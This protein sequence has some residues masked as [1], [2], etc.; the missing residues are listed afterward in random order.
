MQ[1]RQIFESWKEIADYL[2]RSIRTCRRWEDE[3]GLPIHRLDGT[4]SARVF[5]YADE[6]DRW[7][8][9]KLNHIKVEAKSPARSLIL[10]NKWPLFAA[11]AVVV[12]AVLGAF[13]RPL[14]FL[15]SPPIP[16]NNPILA[17]LP[18]ENPAGDEILES[19]RTAF[20]DLLITDL[21]QIPL[22]ECH[23][24]PR[25]SFSPEKSEVGRCKE[26]FGRGPD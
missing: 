5:A 8:A 18:F 2:K 20:P 26:V 19:W 16:S 23:P 25:S 3:L 13:V 6:L 4:P 22:Y 14:L 9:E 10:K 21:R 11:A 17:I 12:I 24:R 1:E 7:L 15:G